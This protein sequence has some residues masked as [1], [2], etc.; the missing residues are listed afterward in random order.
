MPHIILPKEWNLNK[1]NILEESTYFNRKEFLKKLG[2]MS[3]ALVLATCDKKFSQDKK[4]SKETKDPRKQYDP[5]F[6]KSSFPPSQ[7]SKFQSVPKRL[8]TPSLLATSYNNYYEFTQ[9]KE[10]V[11]ILA[12]KFNTRPWQIGVSGLVSPKTKKYY[13]LEKLVKSFSLEERIYRFRCVEAWSMVVPW[14]GI[15]MAKIISFLNPLSKARYVRF[16][17]WERP[18]EAPGQR[19]V[20]SYT[21]PYYEALRMDEAMN[22]LSLFTVGM[23]GKPLTKQNGAPVRLIVPWKYGYKSMKGITHI[24]FLE[25]RPGTFWNDAAPKEYGFYSNVNPKVPHLRWS[26]A[27]EQVLGQKGKINTLAYNGYGKFVAKL[28]TG[29]EF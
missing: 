24:E 4:S 5:T 16:V 26:Q 20:S 13:D 7:N 11:W 3:S 25:K 22:Q 12:S 27:K 9:N 18:L 21:W 8:V 23:Y 19:Q 14:I 10:A 6:A 2:L 17:G 29:K 15:S 28:Y 1:K